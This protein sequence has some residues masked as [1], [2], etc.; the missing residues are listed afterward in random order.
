MKNADIPTILAYFL[1][2]YPTPKNPS[3]IPR[4]PS[5]ER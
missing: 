3:K 2:K 4:E 5:K 1:S